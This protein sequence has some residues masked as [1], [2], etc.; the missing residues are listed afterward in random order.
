MSASNEDILKRKVYSSEERKTG[1]YT[2]E[3]SW[4]Q[5]EEDGRFSLVTSITVIDES[6][7]QSTTPRNPLVIGLR[8][9]DYGS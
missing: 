3:R 2:Y 4:Q 8:I 7:F 9:Y 1:R 5:V 6:S